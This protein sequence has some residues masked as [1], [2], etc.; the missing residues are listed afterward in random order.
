[1]HRLGIKT[2]AVFLKQTETRSIQSTTE[3]YLIGESRVSESYLNIERIIETAKKQTPTPSI[4]ATGYYQKTADSQNAVSRKHRVYR[5][6]TRYHCKM[7]AKLKHEKQ[8]RPQ[9]SLSFPVFL[10]PSET[11]RQIVTRKSNR[12]P[13]HAESFS[14]RRRHRNATC[15]KRGSIN[16]GVRG[17]QKARKDF[18][19]TDRCI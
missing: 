1:M 3:S 6:F 10:N 13:C 17:E 12:I 2:V 19:V 4:P 9:V 18:S 8:W 15:S 14:G 7:G 5:T 11:Y 16:K